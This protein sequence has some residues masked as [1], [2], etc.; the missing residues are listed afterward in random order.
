MDDRKEK[1]RLLKVYGAIQGLKQK[2]EDE[3]KVFDNLN[4]HARIDGD[5][6]NIMWTSAHISVRRLVI[7]ELEKITGLIDEML[8]EGKQ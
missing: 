5:T 2:L 6:E 7:D 3:I 1:V 8:E 4:Q